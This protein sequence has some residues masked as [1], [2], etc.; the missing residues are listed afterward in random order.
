MKNSGVAAECIPEPNINYYKDLMF[1]KH[2]LEIA[3]TLSSEVSKK[4]Q[5]LILFILTFINLLYSSSEE[6]NSN[7]NTKLPR[8]KH[9]EKLVIFKNDNKLY[10]ILMQTVILTGN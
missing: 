8:Y 3:E 1:I 5:V 2:Q 7:H 4:L 10:L 9:E 6:I